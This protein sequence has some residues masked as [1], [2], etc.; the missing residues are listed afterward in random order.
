MGTGV[1]KPPS[2]E[3]IQHLIDKVDRVCRES[4][5]LRAQAERAMRRRVVWP[6]ESQRHQGTPLSKPGDDRS[7]DGTDGTL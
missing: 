5:R 4:E 6:D 2:W 3:D 1:P 7:P